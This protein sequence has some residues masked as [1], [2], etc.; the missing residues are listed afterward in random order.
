[1]CHLDALCA[2]ALARASIS[3]SRADTADLR[4]ARTFEAWVRELALSSAAR[5]NASYQVREREHPLGLVAGVHEAD[6]G[7]ARHGEHLW[8]PGDVDH[9]GGAEAHGIVGR[10][11]GHGPRLELLARPHHQLIL[12]VDRDYCLLVYPLPEWEEIERRIARLGDARWRSVPGAGHYVHIENP[13][14][15]L[16]EIERLLKKG[17]EIGKRLDFLIQELH[18]EANTLGSKSAALE[19]TRIGVDMKVLIEQMREQIQNIE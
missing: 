6:V 12:T 11:V 13:D 15:V 2:S 8:L 17:G 18:R 5:P 4:C 19:L 7:A 16:D 10:R 14:F 1:M 3:I 9:A